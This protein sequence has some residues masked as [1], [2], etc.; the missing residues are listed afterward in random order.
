MN[1]TYGIQVIHSDR[2]D[3]MTELRE[4]VAAELTEVGLHRTV[5]AAVSDTPAPPDAPS[6]GVYLGSRAAVSDAAVAARIQAAAAAGLVVVPVVE[7]LSRFGEHVPPSLALVNGFAWHGVNPARRL[8]RSLL[9]E[10][11]IED[12]QRRVFISHKRDDGLGAAEQLHDELSHK[13]FT[14]FIDRF[15]IRE[16]RHVQEAIADALEDHAFLL[17]LETPLANTSDW[18]FDEVDYA[19][20]HTMGTLILQWP[21]DPTPVPGSNNLPRL[22][23]AADEL[24]TDSHGYEVMTASALDRIVADIEAAHAHGLVRRRRMLLRSIEEAASA[25]GATACIPLPDWRLLV[26]HG[27][28]STLLGIT[29]RLPTAQDL[30][31]LDDARSTV[32]DDTSAVLVHSARTLREERATHLTWVAGDRELELTPENAIG[33]RWR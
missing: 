29:P 6:V 26:E 32:G 23:L 31:L 9:A 19:L 27:G 25:G 30:Q 8:A 1:T 21:G 20:S 14:P 5:A 3:W 33:G 15:A 12:R 2:N 24:T 17:L 4:A 16:G 22:R 13:G 18:V 7:D 11:G 10:L 28:V